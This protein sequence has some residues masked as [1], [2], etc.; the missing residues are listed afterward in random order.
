MNLRINPL[1]VADLKAI[2]D[3]IAEDNTTI[4]YYGSRFIKESELQN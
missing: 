4:S 2:K 3:Y 1:V